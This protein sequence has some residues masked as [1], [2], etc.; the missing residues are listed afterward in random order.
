MPEGGVQYVVGTP[1]QTAVL[2]P[3][4][5]PLYDTE[6]LATGATAVVQLFSDCKRFTRSGSRS[7][8]SRAS[9][10]TLPAR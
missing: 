7:N 3:L 10:T 1:A 5:Q 8:G 9:T 4:R 2:R 6:F